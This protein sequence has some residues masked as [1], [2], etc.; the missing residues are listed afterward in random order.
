MKTQKHKKR[1]APNSSWP[2][3]ILVKLINLFG[4]I[5]NASFMREIDQVMQE[6]CI[7]EDWLQSRMNLIY[8]GRGNKASIGSY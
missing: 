8:E 6:R 5:S 7:P 2:D 4:G 1:F 3:G